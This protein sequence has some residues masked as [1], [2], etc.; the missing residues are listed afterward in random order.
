MNTKNTKEQG[1]EKGGMKTKKEK[2]ARYKQ[3]KGKNFKK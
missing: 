2:I 1:Q 3:R